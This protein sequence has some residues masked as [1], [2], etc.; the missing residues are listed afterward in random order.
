MTMGCFRRGSGLLFVV[1]ALSIAFSLVAAQ[2]NGK[3]LPPLHPLFEPDAAE[4]QAAIKIG[5][6][7]VK[8]DRTIEEL[9]K[10]WAKKVP[11]ADGFV[12]PLTPSLLIAS[13][14]FDAAKY[15]KDSQTQQKQVEAAHQRG[16]E[17]LSFEVV[18]RSKGSGFWLFPRGM[19][20]GD[21]QALEAI[22]FVLADD[23]GRF[24]QPLDAEAQKRITQQNTELGLPFSTS[25]YV[26]LGR[27]YIGIPIPLGGTRQDFE[28]HYNPTFALRAAKG[29]PIL[30]DDNRKFSLRIIGHRGEKSVEFTMSELTAK[31]KSR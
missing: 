23:R 5:E 11:D 4:I 19:K 10:Q 27:V 1:G 24:F 18:L 7:A 2:D 9:H 25:Y 20:P 13:A 14:A 3:N 30:T 28:A 8:R 16:R 29:N 31:A 12:I 22:K 26:P 21:K 17:F 6:N 15:H